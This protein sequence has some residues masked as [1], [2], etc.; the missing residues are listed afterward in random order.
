MTDRIEEEGPRSGE[1]T[2]V[3]GDESMSRGN[4]WEVVSLTASTYAASPG[5]KGL[6]PVHEEKVLET[7]EAET[8]TSQALF[9]SGHFVF[10]PSQHENLPLEEEEKQDVGCVEAEIYVEEGERS[11]G[12]EDDILIVSGLNVPEDF[13]DAEVFDGKS[14]R[15]PIRE[16]EFD[17]ISVMQGANILG[18]EGVMYGGDSYSS[19]YSGSALGG[20][21]NPVEL[22]ES[23]ESSL[24]PSVPH[25]QKKGKDE[26]H[27]DHELPSG[28]WWKNPVARLRSHAKET[29]A[30]WSIFVAAAVMG[31]VILGQKWQQERWQV[32]QQR[33]QLTINSEKPGRA[34]ASLSR[35]KDIF[36]GGSRYNSYVS[37]GVSADH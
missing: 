24:D 7:D 27:D 37:N 21:A 5:P 20:S 23:P 16:L 13:A 19:I 12:K 25:S 33:W 14:E 29:N 4:G 17:E 30:F 31:L 36:V 28:A 8:E 2:T 11:K 15:L 1:P 34:V 6:E 10:P 26:K 9:M 22:I 18:E 35:F 3:G 32:L